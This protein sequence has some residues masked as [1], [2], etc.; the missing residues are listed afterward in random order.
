MTFG[1]NIRKY[2]TKLNLTQEELA[3]KIGISGQA[4]SK[5]E[6]NDSFPDTAI[7]PDIADT[8]GVSLDMLFGRKTVTRDAMAQ[9]IF[10]YLRSE[11]V[12][13][14]EE[15]L[16]E[17]LRAAAF[18]F[19]NLSWNDVAWCEEDVATHCFPA[20]DNSCFLCHHNDTALGM[21]SKYPTFPY[22]AFLRE[23]KEGF[24][25]L[26]TEKAMQYLE[27]LGDRDVLR[28][29]TELLKRRDC[30]VETAVLL[31]DAGVVPE[32]EEEIFEKM[33]S[34]GH[35][36]RL[37]KVEINGTTRRMLKFDPNSST[38]PMIPL[39]TIIAAAY[40]ATMSPIAVTHT[41]T[42]RKNPI[43]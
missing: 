5:W 20:T 38:E 16:Y 7:L 31:R 17:L 8:L 33:K 9:S 2:R 30:F 19:N 21:F 6:T 42:H 26:F 18:A 15:R 40:A 32:K 29:V 39:M 4:V 13:E 22:A 10:D 27:S 41:R 3:E 1:E 12:T 37:R 11:D 36:V 28:C 14:Q 43:L 34:F 35:L 23:P 24:A 25:S